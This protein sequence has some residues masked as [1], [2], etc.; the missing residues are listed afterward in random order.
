MT[1]IATQNSRFALTAFTLS[2]LL[3]TL[4]IF[5]TVAALTLPQVSQVIETNKQRVLLKETIT[6]ISQGMKQAVSVV[7]RGGNPTQYFYNHLSAQK[8]CD[9]DFLAQGC[10]TD[11][12]LWPSEPAFV[13][14]TGV[15]VVGLQPG[16]GTAS[17]DGFG[18]DVNGDTGPNIWGRDRLTL[19]VCLNPEIVNQ[20]NRILPVSKR[21]PGAVALWAAN[22][23]TTETALYNTLWN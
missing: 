6:T 14:P 2:E 23:P 8:V 13:L 3:I 16:V 7:G 11:I 20:C 1:K 18:I 22:V 19:L 9:T 5:G 21:Q 4:A 15:T 10:S 12:T 17:E